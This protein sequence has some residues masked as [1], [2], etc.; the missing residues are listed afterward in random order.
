MAVVY[1]E[2][3]KFTLGLDDTVFQYKVME[4]TGWVVGSLLPLYGRFEL[5]F[6]CKA[7]S[8]L[9][10][11]FPNFDF[12]SHKIMCILTLWCLPSGISAK[13]CDAENTD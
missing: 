2:T 4:S 3:N 10:I 11:C 5:I 8:T 9:H 1:C 6:C 12:E 7:I 13:Q